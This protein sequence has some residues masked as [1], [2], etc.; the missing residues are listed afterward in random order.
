MS[1]DILKK[2][3]W[4]DKPS[5]SESKA[6]KQWGDDDYSAD[7]DDGAVHLESPVSSFFWQGFTQQHLP[8]VCFVFYLL[9]HSDDYLQWET[10]TLE[11]KL[12]TRFFCLRPHSFLFFLVFS[13]LALVSY[14]RPPTN[15]VCTSIC[16]C[17]CSLMQMAFAQ[18]L[19]IART[20]SVSESRS[21]AK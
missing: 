6:P 9:G 3:R 19:N 13:L 12:F 20:S 21:F 5:A 11:D 16:L 18:W 17:V 8:S 10:D 1:S 14:P 2:S 4:A 15:A 7:V